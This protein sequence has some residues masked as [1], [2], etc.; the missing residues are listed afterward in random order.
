MQT[1]S[2]YSNF[3]NTSGISWSIMNIKFNHCFQENWYLSP[4]WLSRSTIFKIV[5]NLIPIKCFLNFFRS[6]L[7]PFIVTALYIWFLELIVKFVIVKLF[8]NLFFYPFLGNMY[9]FSKQPVLFC[10]RWACI[11]CTDSVILP[12]KLS[13]IVTLWQSIQEC[14]K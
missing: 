2:D 4:L 10:E 7:R 9:F 6:T 3:L 13:A 1:N 12:K 5:Y 8:V 14:T 11:S